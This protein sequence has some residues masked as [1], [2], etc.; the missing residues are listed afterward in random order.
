MRLAYVDG[1]AGAVRLGLARPPPITAVRLPRLSFF[2]RVLVRHTLTGALTRP[3]VYTRT[4]TPCY[5]FV[6][7]TRITGL[8]PLAALEKLREPPCRTTLTLPLRPVRLKTR[9]PALGLVVAVILWLER[10]MRRRPAGRGETDVAS[11]TNMSPS[12]HNVPVFLSVC[13]PS[14]L[15]VLLKL[16]TFRVL[17]VLRTHICGR[18]PIFLPVP[19]RVVL[20]GVLVLPRGVLVVAAELLI[21]GRGRNTVAS[22]PYRA[23]PPPQIFRPRATP[24]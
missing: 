8:R 6:V 16:R 17:V 23:T 9:L 10:V 5:V 14:P 22:L 19:P 7:L 11:F 24:P 1:S 15:A 18:V 21:L 2:D 12:S 3:F 13:V 4:L 20:V